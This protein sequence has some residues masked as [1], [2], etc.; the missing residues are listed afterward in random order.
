M[1]YFRAFIIP[2]GDDGE[3][4]DEIEVTTDVSFDSIGKISQKVDNSEYDVGI[5]TY[6]DFTLKLRNEHGFYSKAGEPASIFNIKRNDSI[7]KVKWQVEPE[8]CIC[9]MFKA[10]RKKLSLTLD[11]YEGFIKDIA[12]EE[13]VNDQNVV[14]KVLS[15]E[16]ILSQVD[17]PVT[18]ATGDTME[19]TLFKILNQTILTDLFEIDTAN[20]T[21][22]VD[23]ELDDAAPLL[24]MTGKEALDEL[25]LLSNSILFIKERVLI[26]TARIVTT[27]LK[28]EFYGPSSI[29]GLENIQ[30]ISNINT[31]ISRAFNFWTWNGSNFK[32]VNSSSI[33]T[34]GVRKKEITSDIVTNT[35]KRQTIAAAL[36]AEFGDPRDTLKITTPMNYDTRPLFF[37]DKIKVDFPTIYKVA[38]GETLPIY[39]A[40]FYG[41]AVYPK[42]ESFLTIDYERNFKIMGVG[43]DVKNNLI[44]FEIREA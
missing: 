27:D 36:A 37:L 41:E 8:G 39:G 43:V 13:N 25:L 35:V 20:W 9:G 31:G 21:L 5:L 44:E 22:G 3:Y 18:V 26:I 30:D 33:A 32:V 19:E 28:F 14:L 2:F 11:V 38:D 12:V 6:N 23:L 29:I 7:F 15:L 17:V 34:F 1:S 42:R 4:G 16:S 40:S 24:T 10:G